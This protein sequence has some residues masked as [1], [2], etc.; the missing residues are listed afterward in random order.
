MLQNNEQIIVCQ[1][2]DLGAK[3]S[4]TSVLFSPVIG[5][6]FLPKP[7]HSRKYSSTD[8]APRPLANVSL[9][10]TQFPLQSPEV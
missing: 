2:M 1:V 7:Q 4:D 6:T 8:G 5:G 10:L 9:Q 3:N